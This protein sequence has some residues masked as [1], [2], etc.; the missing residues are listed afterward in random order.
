MI[1]SSSR[2]SYFHLKIKDITRISANFFSTRY[3]FDISKS[4]RLEAH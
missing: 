2:L 4:A 3:N 1:Q